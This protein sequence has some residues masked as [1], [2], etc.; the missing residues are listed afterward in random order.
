MLCL[1]SI[2]TQ[3]YDDQGIED[4]K[5]QEAMA[6]YKAG[7]MVFVLGAFVCMFFM[8]GAILYSSEF[9]AEVRKYLIAIIIVLLLLVC[10]VMLTAPGA[11]VLAGPYEAWKGRGF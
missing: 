10:W 3:I 6:T 7:T 2:N 8:M 4:L 5:F 11:R 1:G 9:P